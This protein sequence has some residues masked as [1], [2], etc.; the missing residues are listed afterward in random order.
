[1]RRAIALCKIDLTV[2]DVTI[3]MCE[4]GAQLYI[5]DE[6]RDGK[7]FNVALYSDPLKTFYATADQIEVTDDSIH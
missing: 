7:V 5:I 2:M 4:A 1:M 6:T 3:T